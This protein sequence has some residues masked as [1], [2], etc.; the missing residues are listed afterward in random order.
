[1]NKHLCNRGAGET[2]KVLIGTEERGSIII[3]AEEQG[4]IIIEKNWKQ[5]NRSKDMGSIIIKFQF[6]DNFP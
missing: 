6:Q 1:L 4:K 5:G 3:G 2:G